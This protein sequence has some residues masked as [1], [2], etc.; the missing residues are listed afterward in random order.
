M[1]RTK[2]SRET[3]LYM[4]LGDGTI[5]N[6]NGYFST[7]HSIK[8][9][10]Y[11]EWKYNLLKLMNF[12]LSELY[13]VSNNSYGAYEFRTKTYKFLKLYRK[14]LY[15]NGKKII[16]NRKLLNKLNPLGIAIWYMDDGGLA[17]CKKN[18]KIIGNQL[19][20]NTHLSKIENQIIIDYFKEVWNINFT[21]VKNKNQYRLRCGLKEARKFVDIVKPYV[22]QIPSM[23][24]KIALK[25]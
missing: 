11:I 8:Q 4:L 5:H 6:K 15:P 1:K 10:D 3:L 20:L 18:G 7:R 22:T 24:H 19:I 13:F 12:N 16:S 14:V 2:Q 17:Q 23:A 25:S 21:Q 9:K